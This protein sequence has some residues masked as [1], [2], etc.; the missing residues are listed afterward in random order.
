MTRQEVRALVNAELQRRGYSKTGSISNK[1]ACK[2]LGLMPEDTIGIGSQRGSRLLRAW[3]EG[4]DLDFR[5]LGGITSDIRR[6][7]AVTQSRSPESKKVLRA[8]WAKR[9]GFYSRQE[10]QELRYK[11]LVMHGAKCQCCGRGR[12]DGTTIHV[13]HIKP[14][15]K[16]PELSLV[17]SNLQVL[18]EDCNLGKSNKD[19]TDWR[20]REEAA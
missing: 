20:D 12:E 17:L 7:Q 16:F 9:D 2:I 8:K 11:A 5:T 10:W 18:C 3:V 6:R 19:D 13:D 14:R 15:S 4:R 1:E